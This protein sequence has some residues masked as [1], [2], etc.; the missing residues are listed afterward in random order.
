MQIV[1]NKNGWKNYLDFFKYPKSSL[2]HD[3]LWII[4][5][6]KEI[7]KLECCGFDNPHMN[8]CKKCLGDKYYSEDEGCSVSMYRTMNMLDVIGMPLRLWAILLIRLFGIL[9]IIFSFPI[10]L[11]YNIKIQ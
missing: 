10:A 9:A 1:F 11:L 7:R 5:K 2:I 3:I 8:N 4:G 6:I